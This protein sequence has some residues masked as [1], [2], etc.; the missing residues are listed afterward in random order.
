MS[1]GNPIE[2]RIR[3]AAILLLAGLAVEAMTLNVLHPLSFILFASLGVLLIVVGIIVYLLA[4]LR[5]GESAGP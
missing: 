3:L 2:G 1:A 5:A 4:L